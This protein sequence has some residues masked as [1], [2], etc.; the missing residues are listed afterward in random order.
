[1]TVDQWY[2]SRQGQSLLVPGAAE[3]DRGQCVQAADYALNEIYGLAYVWANA[4]DW[5]NSAQ[6]LQN[7]DQITDGSVKKG[8]F[9]IFNSNVGSVYGHVDL[10]MADGTIDNLTGADSNWGGNKTVHLVNHVGRQYVVGSLRLKGS[11]VSNMIN[12]ADIAQIRI[13]M[14]EVEGWNGNDIHSGKDDAQI[15]AAWVG[16]KWTDFIYHSWSVQPTHRQAVVDQ[17]A[18]LQAQLADQ[19]YEPAPPTYVKKVK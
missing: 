19:D 2:N 3:A 10:A 7:F 1:M 13:I 15:K 8:D 17:V 9:V 4:I 14:S 5:W 18:S 11:Q 12:D 6:V 16:Q